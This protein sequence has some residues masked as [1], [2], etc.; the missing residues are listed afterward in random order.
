MKHLSS[1]RG[2]SLKLLY[3]AGHIFYNQVNERLR[4]TAES[5]W[6]PLIPNLQNKP[7]TTTVRSDMLTKKKSHTGPSRFPQKY[8]IHPARG[9]YSSQQKYADIKVLPTDSS[10][11]ESMHLSVVCLPTSDD[12]QPQ[13]LLL[14]SETLVHEGQK[15]P[16][17]ACRFH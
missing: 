1:Q 13:S 6:L 16:A 14:L 15:Q 11:D 3:T 4:A 12:L 17:K 5:S 2:N 8:V 10:Q 7:P 9:F